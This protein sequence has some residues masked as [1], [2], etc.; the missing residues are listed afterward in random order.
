MYVCLLCIFG[1]FTI[2]HN[3]SLVLEE[4]YGLGLVEGILWFV[5][6]FRIWNQ[7]AFKGIGLLVLVYGSA[8]FFA[9]AVSMVFSGVNNL[10]MNHSMVD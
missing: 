9:F 3:I 1:L 10:K 6:S 2:V 8:A 5:L 4:D 7:N